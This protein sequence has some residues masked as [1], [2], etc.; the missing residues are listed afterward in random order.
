M[1]VYTACFL[2]VPAA[3]SYGPLCL[4]ARAQYPFLW[5]WVSQHT[6]I[7]FVTRDTDRDRLLA[8]SSLL[9]AR[10]HVVEPLLQTAVHTMTSLYGGVH[11]L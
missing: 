10:V 8:T 3:V 2:G 9:P 11:T 7:A 5:D 1:T 6:A 4:S